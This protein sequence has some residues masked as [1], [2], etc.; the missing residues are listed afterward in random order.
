MLARLSTFF[1][2][3]LCM[4]MVVRTFLLAQVVTVQTLFATV[5]SMLG[6]HNPNIFL[7]LRS[8]SGTRNNEKGTFLSNTPSTGRS[9]QYRNMRMGLGHMA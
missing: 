6:S 5:G 2:A 4:F 3:P 8:R 7:L 9:E 1:H